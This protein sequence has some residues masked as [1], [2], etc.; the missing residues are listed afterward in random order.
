MIEIMRESYGILKKN[1]TTLMVWQ[2]LQIICVFIVLFAF[3]AFLFA[4]FL[5]LGVSS[6]LTQGGFDPTAIYGAITGI[7]IILMF[8]L[9]ICFIVVSFAITGFFN[10]GI[11]GLCL[12]AV[13]G[14][15]IS[16]GSGIEFGK[17]FW[18]T[19]ALAIFLYT[20]IT[21]VPGWIGDIFRFLLGDSSVIVGVLISVL[22]ALAGIII[23][24]FF[25]YYIQSI[26][27][28]G[29][30]AI[31]CLVQSASF[32]KNNLIG[33]FV[34]IVL[35]IIIGIIGFVVISAPFGILVALLYLVSGGS[36]ILAGVSGIIIILGII[37]YIMVFII[38]TILFGAYYY[39]TLT[40][41]Y[42]KFREYS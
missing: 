16:I 33:A 14:D 28:D 6:G 22:F 2:V 24:F 17:K 31:L 32:V 29:K 42:L 1:L 21:S 18:V 38:Y 11:V 25:L 39:V 35:I 34:L 23:S 15:E 4:M 26:V 3:L 30:N 40:N 7:G 27:I 8:I 10:T 5:I 13:K 36:E 9:F 20:L 19:G 37:L 41:F 12:N